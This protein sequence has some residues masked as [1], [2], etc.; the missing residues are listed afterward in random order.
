M[1]RGR[2]RK[3]Y[4]LV[5]TRRSASISTPDGPITIT[6]TSRATVERLVRERFGPKVR[7][8]IVDTQLQIRAWMPVINL[9]GSVGSELRRFSHATRSGVNQ[10]FRNAQ[11]ELGRE[12]CRRFGSNLPNGLPEE[13]AEIAR[14]WND[15]DLGRDQ[16]ARLRGQP[17]LS[18][19]M[20]RVFQ[21]KLD[22][23][24][25][26]RSY[27]ETVMH[28]VRGQINV[29]FD[30]RAYKNPISLGELK[31][32]EVTQ[33]RFQEFV[34]ALGQR[35]QKNGQPLSA[36]YIKRICDYIRIAWFALR[37]DK[38]LSRYASHLAFDADTLDLPKSR[39]KARPNTMY[40]QHEVER[41][42]DACEDTLDGLI[43]ILGLL[44]IR[45][46][47]EGRGLRWTD[48]QVNGDDL[49]LHVRQ[50][51]VDEGAAAVVRHRKAT[52]GGE[53]VSLYIPIRLRSVFNQA[54]ATARETNAFMLV[55]PGGKGDKPI[56]ASAIQG[57]FRK[58]RERAGV[59]RPGATLYALRHTVVTHT[60]EL[61]GDEAGRKIGAWST[62]KIMIQN[63]DQSRASHILPSVGEKL[64]WATGSM[65]EL[66]EP[67]RKR[68][69]KKVV[70]KE[71]D[72]L[73]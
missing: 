52:E 60:V 71:T 68:Y 34:D 57:R 59:I 16:S 23:K 5:V 47:G 12:L 73:S 54:R 10:A 39:T 13:Y 66:P 38:L 6:A 19:W 56:S 41:L 20:E 15:I 46:P 4:Q 48:L 31:V 50:Q 7:F 49:W 17:T 2:R 18:E 61:G 29:P 37:R 35:T 44:G 51:V 42:F 24:M 22:R 64:P 55:K 40:T 58:I 62:S 21:T 26:A 3:N 8:E 63:Y 33:E 72:D 11:A 9:D 36:T 70:A 67:K 53:S 69:P 28:V 32:K 65:N 45:M 43:L 30:S 14:A 25:V 27:F 1:P